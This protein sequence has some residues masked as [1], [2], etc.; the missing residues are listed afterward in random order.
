MTSALIDAEKERQSRS[1][2]SASS[3]VVTVILG[4]GWSSVR[5][6]P[7]FRMTGQCRRAWFHCSY[8]WAKSHW[9]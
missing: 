5:L 1:T 2:W 4:G 3:H 6:N 9:S 7:S 8:G